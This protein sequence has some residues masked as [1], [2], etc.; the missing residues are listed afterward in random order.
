MGPQ[1]HEV[2][3]CLAVLAQCKPLA[4]VLP[5]ECASHNF[6]TSSAGQAESGAR[7]FAGKGAGSGTGQ[8]QG[9]AAFAG[10]H[11]SYPCGRYPQRRYQDT[12]AGL[13][14]WRT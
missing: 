10:S 1:V 14:D 9:Q 8:G 3:V 11:L 2:S 6:A 4:A 5:A 12:P 7:P 13:S